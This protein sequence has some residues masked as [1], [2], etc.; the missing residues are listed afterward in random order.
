MPPYTS[1]FPSILRHAPPLLSVLHHAS[2]F[3]TIP[4]HFSDLKLDIQQ[5]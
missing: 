5:C 2:L 4:H 1:P 3:L